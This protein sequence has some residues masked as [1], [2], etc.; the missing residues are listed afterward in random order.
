VFSAGIPIVMMPLD[1]THKA[2]T[3]RARV[4]AFRAMGTRVG[5]ATAELLDFFER[6]DEAEIRLRRRPAARSLRHR[7]APEA[8][9]LFRPPLQCRDRDQC[10]N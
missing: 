5:I 7:L 3:T 6:F 9:T 1:V 2:L 10:R 4:E 8:G